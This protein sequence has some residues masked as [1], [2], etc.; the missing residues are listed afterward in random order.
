MCDTLVDYNI[1]LTE[2]VPQLATE[3]KVSDDG[4]TYTFTIRD[5]AKFQAGQYQEGRAVVAEDVKYSLERSATESSM[6]RLAML[7]HCNV[8]DDHTVEC[9]LK[10]PNA[11][12]LTALTDAGNVIIP[13]EEVEGWGDAFGDHLVGS[14]AFKLDQFVKDQQSDLSRSDCYWGEKPHLD[15]LTVKVVTD[16]TQSANGLATGEIDI[17]TSLTARPPRPS[18]TMTSSCWTRSRHFTLPTST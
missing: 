6:N 13:K 16:M 8:V 12:F 14:G 17:A 15:G 3:W 7:D 5:D 10:A 2:I 9:V 11:S 4:L 1:D 18:R